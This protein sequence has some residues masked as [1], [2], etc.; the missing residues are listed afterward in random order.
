VSSYTISITPDQ[1]GNASATMR[2]DVGAAGTRI[3]ELTVRAGN[4]EG[5]LFDDLPGFDL[6]RLLRTI[7]S[8]ATAAP[9]IEVPA[10]GSAESGIVEAEA[11]AGVSAPVETGTAPEAD[12]SAQPAETGRAGRRA[13][14]AKAGRAPAG[15]AQRGGRRAGKA[16]SAT[17]A[18]G[19]KATG[20]AGRS[21]GRK[22]NGAQAT[23]GRAYRRMPEDIIEA[24]REAGSVS[25]VA[26]HYGVPRHTAQGWIGRLRKEGRLEAS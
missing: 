8:G 5:I 16:A 22:A 24:F 19:A 21:R 14:K 11:A 3:T 17:A 2:V 23:E 7:V 1:T 9:A 18:P 6:G 15:R 25:G 20:R 10:S 12:A 13:G 26:A 4:G